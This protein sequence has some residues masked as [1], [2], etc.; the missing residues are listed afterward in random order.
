MKNSNLDMDINMDKMSAPIV[1]NIEHFLVSNKKTHGT[2]WPCMEMA[3]DMWTK[4]FCNI[5]RC[6]M[7]GIFT[8]IWVIFGVNVGKYSIHG[9]YG[10]LIL[11]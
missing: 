9:A 2:E 7:Y 3:M 6:S 5:P 1:L 10:I 11:Q 8:Y 4:C